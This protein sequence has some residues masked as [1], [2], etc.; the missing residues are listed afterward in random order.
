MAGVHDDDEK[1]AGVHYDDQK[2]YN[3]ML[4]PITYKSDDNRCLYIY[5]YIYLWGHLIVSKS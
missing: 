3:E 4:K 2:K 1:M 5:I